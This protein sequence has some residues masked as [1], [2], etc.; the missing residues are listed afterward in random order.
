MSWFHKDM[1]K[2]FELLS[3]KVEQISN[4]CNDKKGHA[5]EHIQEILNLSKKLFN[6]E[7]RKIKSAVY[8]LGMLKTISERSI[9]NKIK[10]GMGYTV[11][12]AFQK[13]GGQIKKDAG[14]LAKYF[15]RLNDLLIK[16]HQF[17]D[18]LVILK[19]KNIEL[20][21][22]D[23]TKWA[24]NLFL[25]NAYL[26]NGILGPI[27]LPNLKLKVSP[28]QLIKSIYSL[29]SDIDKLIKT[30]KIDIQNLFGD[31]PERSELSIVSKINKLEVDMA[32]AV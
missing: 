13:L 20:M 18:D 31:P 6:Y 16:F 28:S 10:K 17:L 30:Y 19:Q 11:D 21:H 7:K 9:K 1:Y 23:S 32:R 15:R 12:I 25:L 14:I 27:R 4:K 5:Q 2:E 29:L 8:D 26:K 24:Y 3:K 22:I